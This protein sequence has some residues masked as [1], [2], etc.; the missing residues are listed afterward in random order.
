VTTLEKE[1]EAL[2]EG[3]GAAVAVGVTVARHLQTT[4]AI[5]GAGNG[6]RIRQQ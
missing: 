6:D 1:A 5:V 2:A 3:T 4:A